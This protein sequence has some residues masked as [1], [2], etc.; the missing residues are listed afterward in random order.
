[1]NNNN[2]NRYQPLKKNQTKL[3]KINKK[4]FLVKYN[5]SHLQNKIK[6]K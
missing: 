6:M 4:I 5:L 2:N 1:M 3:M